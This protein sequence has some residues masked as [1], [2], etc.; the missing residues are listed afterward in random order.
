MHRKKQQ[1]TTKAK[2]PVSER[3]VTKST[4]HLWKPE[5]C[6]GTLITY[7]AAIHAADAQK[8]RQ[9]TAKGKIPVSE[10]KVTISTHH[11]SSAERYL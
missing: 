11:Q 6:G 8:K 9:L 5:L 1:L 2:I 4:Y 3:K 10:G 7:G